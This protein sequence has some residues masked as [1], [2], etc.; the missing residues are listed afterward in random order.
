[1]GPADLID[2]ADVDAVLVLDPQWF[3]LWPIEHA[4]RRGRPV[5]CAA[6]LLEDEAHADA[7]H[8]QV[9]SRGLPVFMAL[10][11]LSAGVAHPLAHLLQDRLGPLRLLQAVQSLSASAPCVSGSQLLSA[12]P[13]LGLLALTA[14]LF[15][16]APT[17]VSVMAGQSAGMA[18]VHLELSAGRAAQLC[19]WRAPG[20]ASRCRLEAVGR[21]ELTVDFPC[22]LSWT[23][24]GARHGVRLKRQGY[25]G[26]LLQ[27]FLRCLQQGRA[28]DPGFA[29]AYQA[30]TWL[31]AARQSS[32]EGRRIVLSE[33]VKPEQGKA[34]LP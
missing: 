12:P 14:R 15:R 5:F 9:Q 29:E 13:L 21:G 32:V 24:D 33:P 19:L 30:L 25:K 26:K 11:H 18:V 20:L 28:P 6:S 7:L 3:G 31:R 16:E 23:E 8:A 1:M 27:R 4:C 22:R 34:V 10:P 2:R 17:S